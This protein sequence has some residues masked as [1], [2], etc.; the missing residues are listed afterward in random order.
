MPYY[1][2][3]VRPF[4]PLEKVAEFAR[5]PEASAHAK[6]LRGAPSE[7]AGER[8]KVMFAETQ[9]AAEDLLCQW[10]DGALGPG[11]D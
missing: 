4:A 11:D 6:A 1:V 3:R 5:F 10:R 2:F 8:V 9:E 7:T